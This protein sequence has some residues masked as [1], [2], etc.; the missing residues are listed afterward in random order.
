MNV[1]DTV[2]D[3]QT[4]KRE[5]DAAI[6]RVIDREDFILGE[7]V[8]CFEAEAADYLG[9][10]HA[11]GLNSGTDAFRIAL[12][13]IGIKP[14]DE[15]ILP[16]F[17]FISDAAAV[18]LEGGTPVFADIDPETCNLDARRVAEKITARTRA[19]IPAH[20]YGV[21]VDLDPLMKLVR[22][23]NLILIEDACQAFGAV[24]RGKKAGSFGDF[25]GFSFYPTKPIGCYGDAGLVV[26]S[27]DEYAQRIKMV[28]NHGSRRRY[29]H[30]F[31]G[32]SSRLD[33][34][35]AAV[36]RVE[37]KY[38]EQRLARLESLR[39]LYDRELAGIDAIVLPVRQ[40]HIREGY[41][42][43]TIR[44][45]RRDALAA[46]LRARGIECGI[47]Y[48]LCI[49]LQ[50]AFAHLGHKKGD[51]PESERAQE[52]VLSLPFSAAVDEREALRVCAAVRAFFA[53]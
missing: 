27:S 30:D 2:F 33:T 20:M 53:G 42:H 45:S 17:C 16:P 14:G 43:Y 9:V 38:F 37:L 31:I 5:I 12:A 50:K 48:P 13:A 7:D 44:T 41:T 52:E 24:Y 51:F 6:R 11:V 35:Q 40:A 1:S 47:F 26:T 32:F 46:C 8:S 15:V 23:R 39:S 3:R 36:L 25:A 18:A 29:Y 49:H 19:V 21:P 10:K 4:M 22:D 34:I 28:R